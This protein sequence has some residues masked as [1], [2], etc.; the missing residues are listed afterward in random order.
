MWWEI[1]IDIVYIKDI[2]GIHIIDNA[3][4]TD[5]LGNAGI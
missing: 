3:D 2:P 1:C 4:I 5:I